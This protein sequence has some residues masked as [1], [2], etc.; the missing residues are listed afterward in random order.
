MVYYTEA[1]KRNVMNE[2]EHMIKEYLSKNA[3][4]YTQDEKFDK[5]HIDEYIEGTLKCIEESFNDV[6]MTDDEAN[7]YC[8]T[9]KVFQVLSDYV[10]DEIGEYKSPVDTI[11]TAI[12][13]YATQNVNSFIEAVMVYEG[14]EL[15][16]RLK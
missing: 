12:Y 2:M 16:D 1:F 14:E 6:K 7:E 5:N 10:Y 9:M 13:L 15:A 4:F 11:Q 8:K 3:W